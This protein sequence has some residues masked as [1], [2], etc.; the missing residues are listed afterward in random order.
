MLLLLHEETPNIVTPK[1]LVV[2]MMARV[3]FLKFLNSCF[4][5]SYFFI[6]LSKSEAELCT[7]P[8]A[9]HHETRSA[10]GFCS[11]RC[12]NFVCLVFVPHSTG[13]LAKRGPI[14]VGLSHPHRPYHLLSQEFMLVWGSSRSNSHRS[15]NAKIHH[16]GIIVKIYI[17]L[18]LR[19]SERST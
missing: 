14:T 3:R 4:S 15:F 9:S 18:Y 7:V 16:D 17:P 12:L 5:R 13:A 1:R 10:A 6:L 8:S 2:L 11:I 19:R